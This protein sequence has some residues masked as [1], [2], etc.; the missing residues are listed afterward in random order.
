MPP[1]CPVASVAI[2]RASAL[3]SVS[4][5]RPGILSLTVFASR[6][7]VELQCCRFHRRFY[8]VNGGAIDIDRAVE[9]QIHVTVAISQM[10]FIPVG[11]HRR[12]DRFSRLKLA[13]VLPR[14]TAR[15]TLPD[16][17]LVAP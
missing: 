9:S 4:R 3:V 13:Y 8:F 10:L 6:R 2:R 12:T 1:C 17:S 16:A 14:V 5:R 7:G 15:S 11:S